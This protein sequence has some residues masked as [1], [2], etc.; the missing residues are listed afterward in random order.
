MRATCAHCGEPMEAASSR[1]RFCSTTCRVRAH[2]AAKVT[3]LQRSER[4]QPAGR[5][6]DA[7]RAELKRVGRESSSLGASALLLAERIDAGKEPGSALAALNRE[8]RATLAEALRG[9]TRSGVAAMRDELAERR[10][11]A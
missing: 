4:S 5:V 9:E 2:E 8:L 11:R 1:K 3:P 7:V 6:A 10:A